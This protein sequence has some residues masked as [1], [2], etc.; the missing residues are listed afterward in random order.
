MR[1]NSRNNHIKA[2]LALS[3]LLFVN[4]PWVNAAALVLGKPDTVPVPAEEPRRPG[5]I[6]HSRVAHGSNDIA[7]TWLALAT[8]RYPHGVLGDSFEASRLVVES[9]EGK[10]LILDLPPYRVFEDLQ[11]RLIDLD[12][13]SRDEI[14]VV[15]SD[16][17]LG[18]SLSVYG[19]VDGLLA[20]RTATPFLG[21]PN[22]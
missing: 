14:I 2:C 5:Q 12:G 19:I 10:F 21:R 22:R 7:G 17:R 11:P 8:D 6:P 13:D 18:A 3:F 20:K 15:E 9:R 16:T 1:S 4:T